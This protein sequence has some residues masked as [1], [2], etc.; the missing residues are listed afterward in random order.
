MKK[1]LALSAAALA[2]ATAG[3]EAHEAGN[4]ILRA[5]AA[6]VSP[7][8]SSS[9]VT[10]GGA[11][12][13]GGAKVGNDTQLG[14]TLAYMLTDD[15]GV[16]LLAATPFKHTVSLK[17]LGALNGKFADVKQLPPTLSLQW[18]PAGKESRWQPY[19]GAGINFTAFFNEKLTSERK[20]QGFSDLSL[21]NSTGLALQ[22]GSD[23]RITDELLFNVSVWHVDIDTTARAKLGGAPVK[24]K[25]DVD[26]WV[27]MVG[28]GYRF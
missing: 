7:D 8:D 3:A 12:I 6:M 11:G 20:A 27:F 23:Y 15:F 9:Q 21:S 5:G 17:G 4:F 18:Y 13:G 22:I 25:V 16:E 28:L 19:V 26:P 1:T 14:L 10:V 2:L 24:V